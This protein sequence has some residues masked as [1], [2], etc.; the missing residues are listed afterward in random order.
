MDRTRE[1]RT[2]MILFFLLLISG[3]LLLLYENANAGIQ[4]RVSLL[5]GVES[6]KLFA[7]GGLNIKASGPERISKKYTGPVKIVILPDGLTVNGIEISGD[8]VRIMAVKGDELTLNDRHFRGIIEVKKKGER[9][10]VI[11]EID[12][13]D[14]LKGVV[15]TEVS[16]AWSVEAL[17]TQAVASRTYALYQRRANINKDYHLV[18]SV[19]DQ[20]Y[21]GMDAEDPRASKAVAATKGMVLKY[22]GELILAMFHSTSPGATED[23]SNLWSIDLPYLKGVECPFDQKSPFYQWKR[24]IGLGELESAIRN[25]GFKIGAVANITPYLWSRSSRV[26]G[27]RIIHSEGELLL[28]GEDLR[29]LIGYSRLPSAN[30]EIDEIGKDIIFSGKG[31][32]H[33]VGLCQW[34]AKEM[35]GMGFRY[36]EILR[37][38]FPGA[39]IALY[40]SIR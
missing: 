37:Y 16:P 39:E 10:I 32:G 4:I 18:S 14:Y 2:S 8:L 6:V 26:I 23:G 27:L 3:F 33:G 22:Y 20:A 25:G 19:M 12:I 29:R 35:A 5:Q 15:P 38:Y 30:F 31:A 24:S 13:E 7:P 17:K 21:N 1:A 40:D 11:N 9:F 28:K 34:G 36:Q